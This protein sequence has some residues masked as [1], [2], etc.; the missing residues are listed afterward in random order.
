MSHLRAN[1]WLLVL[2]IVVCCVLYPLV[3][4]GIGQTVFPTGAQGSLVTDDKGKVVGSRLIAQEFKGDEYF[5]SRPSAA[6]YKADASGASNWSASNYQLRDRVAKQLGPMVRYGKGAEKDGKKPGDLVG[7]D[8]EKW[9]QDWVRR[10]QAGLVA[11]WA[12]AHSGLAEGWI[13]DTDTALK[14]QWKQDGKDRDAGQNFL[15]QLAADDPELHKEVLAALKNPATATPADLATAFFPLFAKR[16][17]NNWLTVEDDPKDTKRKML[18]RSNTSSDLQATFFDMW[19]QAH[20][21]VELEEVPADMVMASGSGLDPHI[22][23]KNARYQLKWRI[24]DARASKIIEEQAIKINKDFKT[25]DR[26][27]QKPI[28]EQARKTLEAKVGKRL[29]DRL[30]EVME[31]LLMDSA[32]APLG[33]LVGVPLINVLEVNLALDQRLQKLLETGK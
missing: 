4:W 13:K 29:E 10:R 1:L 33:G 2:T 7:P 16:Y 27:K 9:F 20:P 3:L 5:Q 21:K 6:S 22:T 12:E 25:L 8:I 15:L 32:S 23:L 11:Q 14:P 24:V 17:P 18:V 31:A 19:R 26:D 30:T 28:E